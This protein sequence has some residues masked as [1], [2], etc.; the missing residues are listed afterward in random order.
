MRK[1]LVLVFLIIVTSSKPERVYAQ[2]FDFDSVYIIASSPS[3]DYKNLSYS[4][5]NEL[6]NWAS[7]D[8]LTYEKWDNSNSSNL[9]LRKF[10][11]S[12]YFN[13]ITVTSNSNVINKNAFAHSP[14]DNFNLCYIAWQS[15]VNGNWDVFFVE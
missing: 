9:I 1:I 5:R 10:D 15:N 14:W 6:F 2:F 4:V 12:Q 8:F 3:Y 11:R 7:Y 13:E